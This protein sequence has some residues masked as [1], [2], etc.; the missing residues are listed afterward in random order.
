[1]SFIYFHEADYQNA[2]KYADL[3]MKHNRYNA[4]ALV[5]KGNCMFMRGDLEHAR[6]MYQEAMGAEA[7]CL[8]AIC[9]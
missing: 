7:D 2:I 6:N 4:K 3:A 5:N 8:E 9:A 1:M